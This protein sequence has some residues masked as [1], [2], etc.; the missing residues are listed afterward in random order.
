MPSE[1]IN[2]N[3]N[4]TITNGNDQLDD[5]D[6]ITV[7][8]CKGANGFGFTISDAINGQKVKKI[9][10]VKRCG[11]LKQGDLLASVNGIDL[12]NLNHIE[13]VDVLKNHC[14]IGEETRFTVKR[15]KRL[16]NKTTEDANEPDKEINLSPNK[17][18]DLVPKNYDDPNNL[19]ETVYQNNKLNDDL[20]AELKANLALNNN[21]QQ[22]DSS[23]NQQMINN[24]SNVD[25]QNGG[26]N[27]Y[28]VIEANN[29]NNFMN[30]TMIMDNV[31]NEDEYEYFRVFLTRSTTNH[32]FGF[33]IVG[34]RPG[35]NLLIF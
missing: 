4:L 9:L 34:G 26:N 14:Q 6:L 27:L 11:L 2:S 3:N 10:D 30:S 23:T 18:T 24:Y 25:D 31:A 12:A 21:E 16:Q 7:N 15:F 33:R 1:L 8:I 17:T 19:Q 28:S 32:S 20:I 5:F 29:Q 22:I 13:V 35:K